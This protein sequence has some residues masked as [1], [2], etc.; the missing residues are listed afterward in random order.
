MAGSLM[1]VE[2]SHHDAHTGCLVRGIRWPTIGVTRRMP[3]IGPNMLRPCRSAR[4]SAAIALEAVLGQGAYGT[5]PSRAHDLQL[6]ARR[7]RQGIP[8]GA[9]GDATGRPRGVLPSLDPG[10]RRFRVGPRE[11]PGRSQ[12]LG[13]AG[14]RARGRSGARLLSKPTARPTWSCSWWR[15]RPWEPMPARR[16]PV[17]GGRRAPCPSAARWPATDSC[18]GRASS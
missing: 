11:I 15:A 5:S 4:V 6:E 2:R 18:R 3:S 17:A 14:P 10:R 13:T 12:D 8:A 9:A 7:R 16:A 1:S